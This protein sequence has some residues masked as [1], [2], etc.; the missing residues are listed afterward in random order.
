MRHYLSPR[1]RRKAFTLVELLVV[2]AIIGILIGMLLPAVQQVREAARRTECLNNMRQLGLASLNFESAHMSLPDAGFSELGRNQ[3]NLENG[4]SG[5][6]N[7]RSALGAE[8]LGW[9]F[10]ILPFME[11]NNL[12]DLRKQTGLVP[13][14]LE[15]EVSFFTCP[16]RGARLI[17]DSEGDITFY[18]DYAGLFSTHTLAGAASTGDLDLTFSPEITGAPG[19]SNLIRPRVA[20][21]GTLQAN[22]WVGLINL[23]GIPDG[24]SLIRVSDVQSLVPDG[25]SNTAMYAEKHVPADLYADPN[26]PADNSKRGFYIGGYTTMRTAIGRRAA[27]PDSLTTQDPDYQL[28]AQNQSIGG[29]HPGT[30]N[31]VYGDGSTHGIDF[32]ITHLNAYKLIHRSDGMVVNSSEF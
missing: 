27:Y 14:V 29:P 10:Q 4:P 2:I 16:S 30:F 8:N 15:E 3:A 6:P 21:A 31:A 23:A 22:Y 25:S 18:P 13:E 26:N 11:A 28:S 24:T 1:A 20:D 12:F 5:E 9:A 7:V 19:N 17:V 32:N